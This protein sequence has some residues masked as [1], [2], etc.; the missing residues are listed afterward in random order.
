MSILAPKPTDLLISKISVSSKFSKTL[1]A[2]ANDNKYNGIGSSVTANLSSAPIFAATRPPGW[3]GRARRTTPGEA[4][5][6]AWPEADRSPPPRRA[7]RAR[8]TTC[9]GAPVWLGEERP[10]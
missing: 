8:T 5:R 3:P 7:Q 10:A 1:P 4:V 6:L 2:S 9:A